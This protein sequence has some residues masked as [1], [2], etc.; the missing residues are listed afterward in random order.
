[1]AMETKKLVID[2]ST[3]EEEEI[4]IDMKAFDVKV[5]LY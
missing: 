4:T 1:M 2:A 5:Y 3:L